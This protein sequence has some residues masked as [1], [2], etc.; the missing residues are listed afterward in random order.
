MDVNHAHRILCRQS[1]RGRHGIAAMG[2]DDFLVRFQTTVIV[3]LE[4]ARHKDRTYAPP[5]ESEP[6]ITSTLPLLIFQGSQ[7][8]STQH[9]ESLKK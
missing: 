4:L 3:S 5:L 6:A 9:Q 1:S 7:R 8:I 2:R